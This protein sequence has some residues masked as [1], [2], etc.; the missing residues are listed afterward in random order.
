MS[1][2]DPID[3][4]K[5]Y[6]VKKSNQ[7]VGYNSRIDYILLM[8]VER[9]WHSR[10]YRGLNL[11]ILTDGHRRRLSNNVLW[12]ACGGIYVP[13][14]GKTVTRRGSCRRRAPEETTI[15][16]GPPT[17]WKTETRRR[18]IPTRLYHVVWVLIRTEQVRKHNTFI[19]IL[20]I[21]RA[22]LTTCS[23]KTSLGASIAY[24]DVSETTLSVGDGI[25]CLCEWRREWDRT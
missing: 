22:I 16:P 8:P 10:R 9:I 12:R 3:Y 1:Y 5:T 24:R 6:I 18:R 13:L 14:M 17:E 2:V 11:V 7:S 20:S 19:A 4:F 23:L 15:C 25:A 21:F